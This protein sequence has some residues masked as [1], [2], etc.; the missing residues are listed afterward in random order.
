MTTRARIDKAGESTWFAQQGEI[1]R[2]PSAYRAAACEVLQVVKEEFQN[3]LYPTEAYERAMSILSKVEAD[4]SA[5]PAP[6]QEEKKNDLGKQ[7]ASRRSGEA[8]SIES[9]QRQAE[10]L[11]MYA[12]DVQREIDSKDPQPVAM[13]TASPSFKAA[14]LAGASAL[15]RPMLTITHPEIESF[16]SNAVRELRSGGN[17]L[18]QQETLTTSVAHSAP[19]DSTNALAA[20]TD[21]TP[22]DGAMT[23][24]MNAYVAMLDA[25]ALDFEQ[26]SYRHMAFYVR[27]FKD[28]AARL[29]VGCAS[30]PVSEASAPTPERS[31]QEQLLLALLA[32]IERLKARIIHL[33][34]LDIA[35]A[36]THT[37]HD[38]ALNKKLD[39]DYG[40]PQKTDSGVD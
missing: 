7:S 19:K 3:K 4:L 9:D 32:E 5:S 28:A 35:H 38:Y 22:T 14:L 26:G 31:A 39:A 29:K 21:E 8:G 33:E 15:R 24:G 37:D 30:V 23:P 1:D 25:A 12:R 34:S 18:T 2:R 10:W 11:E 13:F 16:I 20:V 27:L 17:Q 36:Q 6:Q 40:P